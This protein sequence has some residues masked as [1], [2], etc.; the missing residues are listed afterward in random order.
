MSLFRLPAADARVQ[1]RFAGLATLLRAPYQPDPEGL[2]IALVGIPSEFTVFRNGTRWGPSQIR[3]ASRVIRPLNSDTR[4]NP[5]TIRGVADF[6]DVPVN[7]LSLTE[8]NNLI[9]SRFDE[10]REAGVRALAVG[11]DHGVSLPVLRALAPDEPLALLHIDAHHD[12][13]DEL[14]GIRDNHATLIRRVIEE[15]IIDPARTVSLGLRGSLYHEQE[16][17]WAEEQGIT[18]ISPS[19]LAHLGVERTAAEI[20]SVF[21]DRPIYIT[22]DIDGL[23]PLEAPGTGV[24]EPGGLS[25]SDTRDMLRGLQGRAVVGADLVE[26]SP[27]L[28]PSGRT[29][30]LAAHLLFEL[31]C[32]LAQSP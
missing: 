6:C 28:D 1:P 13:H 23:D 29:A 9:Q 30:M 19:T 5:F 7:P 11:G 18:V 8:T 17:D 12:T 16:L 22:L 25:F 14:Y 21:G 32:L 3:D 20:R 4:L 24:P 27:A 31:L 26:V 2:D 10:L 15:G